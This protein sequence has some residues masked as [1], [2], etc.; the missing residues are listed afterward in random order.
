MTTI[1][2]VTATRYVA[3]LRKGG[4]LPGLMEADDL[5]TYVVKFRAAADGSRTFL[6]RIDVWDVGDPASTGRNA[7]GRL[8]APTSFAK[9]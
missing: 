4:S 5:G 9:A 2:T 6:F 1:R 3:P 8:A 7:P